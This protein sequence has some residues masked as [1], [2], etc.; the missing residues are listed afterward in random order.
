MLSRS[1]CVA[2]GPRH[3]NQRTKIANTD[4][5]RWRVTGIGPC[6]NFQGNICGCSQSC[7]PSLRRRY[8]CPGTSSVVLHE[9]IKSDNGSIQ[10]FPGNTIVVS[11]IHM[12]GIHTN[13]TYGTHNGR[14]VVE[15]CVQG[16]DRVTFSGS[17]SSA[18]AT[19]VFI[20]A[21]GNSNGK[22]PLNSDDTLRR[23]HHRRC[24]RVSV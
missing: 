22:A 6:G 17:E 20:N 23:K 5:L 13:S 15:H 2:S 10:P 9:D 4:L 12:G 21:V 19:N 7:T 11:C 3:T 8:A 1:Q 24:K 16:V 18:L 14:R